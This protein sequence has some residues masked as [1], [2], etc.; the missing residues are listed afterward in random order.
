MKM[1]ELLAGGLGGTIER[2]VRS[3]ICTLATITAGCA[4]YICSFMDRMGV[5]LDRFDGA[6]RRL[7]RLSVSKRRVVSQGAVSGQDNGLNVLVAF[8]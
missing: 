5:K 2:A 6:E 3:T 7:A 4:A 1:P 8:G